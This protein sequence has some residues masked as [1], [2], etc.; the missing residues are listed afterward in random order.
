MILKTFLDLA[1]LD[2]FTSEEIF[3]ETFNYTPTIGLEEYGDRFTLLGYDTMSVVYN[4]GDLAIIQF[5]IGIII[6]K[7]IW[8]K[9]LSFFTCCWCMRRK[10]NKI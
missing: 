8:Y 1:V 9:F 5:Y 2:I 7:V 10:Q 6:L 3:S 4:L